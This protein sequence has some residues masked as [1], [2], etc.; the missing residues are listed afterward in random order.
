[1]QELTPEGRR[2]VVEVR[3]RQGFSAEAAASLVR[4]LIAGRAAWPSS[5]IPSWAAGA[6]GSRAG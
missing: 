6:S 2:R 5:T 4:S 1:M 3:E